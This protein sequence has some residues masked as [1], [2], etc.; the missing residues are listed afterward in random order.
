M[1][2]PWPRGEAFSLAAGVLARPSVCSTL[3]GALRM[4]SFNL[5]N[6]LHNPAKYP[7]TRSF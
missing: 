7:G 3:Y 4:A 5:E 1:K 6:V 2:H